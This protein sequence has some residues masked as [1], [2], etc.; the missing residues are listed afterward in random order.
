MSWLRALAVQ[1]L[2]FDCALRITDRVFVHRLVAVVIFVLISLRLI[3][4]CPPALPAVVYWPLVFIVVVIGGGS[5]LSRSGSICIGL[6]LVDL[7][8][9]GREW[10][11]MNPPS[12]SSRILPGYVLFIVVLRGSQELRIARGRLPAVRRI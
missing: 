9:G 12:S 10:L 4:A 7:R 6:T 3:V 1:W 11:W 2:R 8:L 5:R